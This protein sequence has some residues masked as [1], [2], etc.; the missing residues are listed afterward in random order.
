M[1]GRLPGSGK[2]QAA[3]LPGWK[4]RDDERSYWMASRVKRFDCL[5]G[6]L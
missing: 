4:H 1:L 5:F 3:A 6:R 2:P